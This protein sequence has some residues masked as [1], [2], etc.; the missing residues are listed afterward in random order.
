MTGG[1]YTGG[2]RAVAYLRV[3]TESQRDD[4]EGLDIQRDRIIEWAAANGRVIVAW[5]ID[6]GVSGE[7]PLEERDGLADALEL[8]HDGDASELVIARLDRLARSLIVQEVCLR[9][10]REMGGAIR[11]VDPSE[12]QQLADGGDD[13]PS[14]TLLR[15]ICGSIAEYERKIIKARLRAGRRRKM[16]R[17]GYGGGVAGHGLTVVDGE[18]EPD[19]ALAELVGRIRRRRAEGATYETIAGELNVDGVPAPTG[20]TWFR[21]TVQRVV[22]RL[23]RLEQRRA[24]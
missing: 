6:A 9:D 7:A 17:G 18:L 3:S 19:P 24:G 15:Q 1:T 5:R 4:G 20:G 8:I 14:R 12:D 10:V 16:A 23:E 21:A 13:D 11:S 22:C 2:T